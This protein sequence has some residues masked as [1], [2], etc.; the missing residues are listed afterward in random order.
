[1][2]NDIFVTPRQK[3]LDKLKKEE[4]KAEDFI[5]GSVVQRARLEAIKKPKR[6]I[7]G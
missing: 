3:E 6:I 2:Y 1:M 4:F 7:T 5:G